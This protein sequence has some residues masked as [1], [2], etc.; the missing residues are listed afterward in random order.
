MEPLNQFNLGKFRLRALVVLLMTVAGPAALAQETGWYTGL[1]VGRA[2]ADMDRGSLVTGLGSAG[3]STAGID[4]DDDDSGWKL[5]GGYSFNSR[6]ALEGSYV[7]LGQFDFN[8]SILPTAV[9]TGDA[10]LRA[11]AVDLVG[12][13]PVTDNLSVFGRVGV[14]NM[15]IKQRFGTSMPA[16]G[17]INGS[18]RGTDGK[19]GAGLQ[20][21]INEAFSLRAELERYRIDDNR[22]TGNRV[23]LAS[24]GFVYRF[25]KRAPAPIVAQPAPAPAPAPVP[26]PTPTPPP[27]LEVTLEASALF[28]FDRS[29][30]KPAG[31]QELD[32]LVGE[33]NG[34]SYDAISVVGH[35]DRIGTREYNLALSERRA[36]AVRSYLVTAGLPAARITARGVNSDEPVTRPDQCRNTGS[37]AA[38][39][40]CL[41]PDRRV[42]VIVVGTRPGR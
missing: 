16:G 30:I 28:D 6:L 11:L 9:Q 12:T 25:G 37:A 14:N 19:F 18:D 17:F 22:V 29:E 39:I 33:I 23:D 35:T 24:V 7:D 41:A 32:R 5:L 40:A 36:N 15:R 26:A 13:L 34:L 4:M 10:S 8:A 38:Q 42:V 1:S 31:R 20:Y 27:L 2:Q 21:Q 3:F